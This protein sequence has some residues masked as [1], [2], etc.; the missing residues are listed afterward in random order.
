M[1]TSL[2]ID[3]DEDD[4][5]LPAPR[6]SRPRDDDEIGEL[7]DRLEHAARNAMGRLRRI[8]ADQ[9]QQAEQDEQTERGMSDDAQDARRDEDGLSD[10]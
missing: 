6:A 4:G 2:P 3:D 8:T 5:G 10:D 9:A 7:S 1:Q